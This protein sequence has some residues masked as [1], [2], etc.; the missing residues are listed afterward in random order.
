MAV[1]LG[2]MSRRWRG[3]HCAQFPSELGRW[4]RLS[5][6][7]RSIVAGLLRRRR[8]WAAACMAPP[9][10]P[11][12]GGPLSLK[13]GRR[14]WGWR[15]QL[16]SLIWAVPALPE[17]GAAGCWSAPGRWRRLRPS[18]SLT[19]RA[20]MWLLRPRIARGRGTSESPLTNPRNARMLR[21]WVWL[22]RR[23]LTEP[24]RHSWEFQGST[25][26]R[27]RGVSRSAGTR[28]PCQSWRGFWL[29]RHSCWRTSLP[30]HCN[31]RGHTE[32]F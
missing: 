24:R 19:R 3:M 21:L 20:A 8:L 26:L 15:N 25:R 23:G 14:C 13:S 31:G 29:C 32:I 16:R 7:H 1:A 17:E 4:S 27:R 28:G 12:K 11:D 30:D 18:F 6:C 22:A 5:R 2:E 9:D 10:L